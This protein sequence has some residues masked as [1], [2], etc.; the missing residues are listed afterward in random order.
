MSQESANPIVRKILWATTGVLGLAAWA[1]CL[2][3]VTP[4][5]LVATLAVLAG[6]VAVTGLMPGQQVRGW[7]AVAVAASAVAAA[8][9][10]T[11]TA[12]AGW[13]LLAVDVLLALQLVVAIAAL[14]LEP[15]QEPAPED[16]FAAYAR[17]VRAYQDYATG[18]GSRWTAESSA[19]EPEDDRGTATAHGDQEAW[20]KY[21][22][23]ISPTA[24]SPSEFDVPQPEHRVARG[25]G[26]P[27]VQ[28]A[29]RIH[30]VPD[31][32]AP[33]HALPARGAQ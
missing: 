25:P 21:T 7:F 27:S 26:M 5:D 12:G 19:A 11:V 23:H 15:R 18:Y 3:A 9:T 8:G 33:G 2:T 10:A 14:L 22:Q 1:V 6:A 28:Q 17:Y 4:P 24:S 16:E 32:A 31:P 20:A 13:S 30:H 29:N